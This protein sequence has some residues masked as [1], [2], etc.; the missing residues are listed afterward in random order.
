ME[1]GIS[2]RQEAD[3]RD[4]LHRLRSHV[5]AIE[6]GTVTYLVALGETLGIS[7]TN[8]WLFEIVRVELRVQ[9]LDLFIN[10]LY[11]R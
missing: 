7:G 1:I 6:R 11:I 2:V 10:F 3:R 9:F 5:L 4:N 8:L